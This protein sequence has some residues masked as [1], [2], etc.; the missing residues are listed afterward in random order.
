MVP[1][2]LSVK[3]R[4]SINFLDV[5]KACYQYRN[6]TESLY[7]SRPMTAIRT[8]SAFDKPVRRQLFHEAFFRRQPFLL[9]YQVSP[10]VSSSKLPTI[11]QAEAKVV[12]KWAVLHLSP[13]KTHL[14][15]LS[16][17]LI[18]STNA[19]SR[20][21]DHILTRILHRILVYQQTRQKGCWTRTLSVHDWGP[22][23]IYSA[24]C[25]VAV[26]AMNWKRII[27]NNFARTRF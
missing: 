24:P 26:A 25:P 13:S 17:V 2:H 27:A 23:P 22:W 19:S 4:R 6:S 21:K 10:L 14:P 3:S 7:Q 15:I 20:S 11:S 1:A 9:G 18:L 12:S 5:S 16:A 8:F